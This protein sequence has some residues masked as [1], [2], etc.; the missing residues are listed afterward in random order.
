MENR[1]IKKFSRS[2]TIC[3][4][5]CVMP[6]FAG[7]AI[8]KSCKE[9]FFDNAILFSHEKISGKFNSIIIDKINSIESYNYFILNNLDDFIDTDFLLLVQWDGYVINPYCWQDENFHYDYIGAVWPQYTDKYNVGNGGFSLRSK[10]LLSALKFMSKDFIYDQPE[11]LVI[12]R[13]LRENLENAHNIIFS[14]CEIANKF[15]YEQNETTVDTFGFHGLWNMWRYID[16]FE[17]ENIITAIPPTY[18]KSYLAMKTFMSLHFHNRNGL[19][20]QIY[21]NIVSLIGEDVLRQSLI[22]PLKFDSNLVNT[23]INRAKKIRSNSIISNTA[24]Q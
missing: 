23:A 15:S 4:I 8:E 24:S 12:C 13:S 7:R 1:I 11:D 20:A 10:K 18:F 22:M 6:F 2:I 5:D 14:P 16:D 9:L 3:A 17:F 21:N 19:A